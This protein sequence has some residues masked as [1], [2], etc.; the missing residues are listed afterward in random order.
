[1]CIY[2]VFEAIKLDTVN[3]CTF[4]WV[5]N[6]T[7]GDEYMHLNTQVTALSDEN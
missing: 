1:M 6:E 2:T 3:T 7:F 4:R 5:R